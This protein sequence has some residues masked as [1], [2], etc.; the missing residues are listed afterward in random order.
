[1]A[2]NTIVCQS[3]GKEIQPQELVTRVTYGRLYWTAHPHA[4]VKRTKR[5]DFFHRGCDVSIRELT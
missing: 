3:C 4:N 5:D 2:D 1:M